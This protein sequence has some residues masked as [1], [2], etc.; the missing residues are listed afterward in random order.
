VNTGELIKMI[1]Q[2]QNESNF[3]NSIR[4]YSLGEFR[5]VPKNGENYHISSRSNRLWS[6][7]K[8]L[9]INMNKG[10]T[11]DILLENVSPETEYTDP[12]NAAH[13][14]IY[15]LRKLL[16]SESIFNNSKETISFTNGCY[17]LN[18]KEDVWIDFIEIEK[19]FNRAE[20]IKKEDPEAGIEYYKKAF[21]IY[22]GDLFPEVY[23]EWVFPKKAYYRSLYLKIIANLSKLYADQKLYDA[24]V[25]VCQKALSIE[26]YE[27]EIH[28]Q[29]ME[30]LIRIGKIKEAKDHYEKTI[31]F[32]E[33]EF[34]IQPSPE[35]Q[36]I[37]QL[38][39]SEYVQIKTGSQEVSRYLI[40][41]EMKGAF[42]CDYRDFYTIYVLE[43][44][45]CERSGN[46]LC[47]VYIEFEN[48]KNVFKSSEYKNSAIKEFK[49]ILVKSLRKGDM[50]SLVDKPRF[51]VL[52]NN[53]EYNLVK[54]VIER[55]IRKYHEQNAFNDIILNIEV[56]PSLPKPK[57]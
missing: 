57:S 8:F 20:A 22:G 15:R 6:L 28:V 7:F 12:A 47:P 32:L 25:E 36:K 51:F 26:P 50:V 54:F 48:G 3:L 53:T 46:A 39:K 2:I 19:L 56:S 44:R 1:E 4:F 23:E 11:P 49:E 29:L 13:N 37:A 45:K 52:L 21:E 38:L 16:N 24:I 33:K 42:F 43:K 17:K 40:N 14:M 31:S 41:D 34:G 5:I 27:E 10:I 55:I 30:N 9:L 35:L 18:F